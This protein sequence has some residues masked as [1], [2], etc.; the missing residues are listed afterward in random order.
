MSSL[1]D[2]WRQTPLGAYRQIARSV[3]WRTPNSAASERRLLLGTRVVMTGLSHLSSASARAP[4]A[5][6]SGS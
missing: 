3:S 2:T 4:S 1:T 5:A 6:P